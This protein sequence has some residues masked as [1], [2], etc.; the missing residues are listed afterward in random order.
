MQPEKRISEL[1]R[2]TVPESPRCVI[3]HKKTFFLPTFDA[4]GNF[5]RTAWPPMKTYGLFVIR[6]FRADGLKQLQTDGQ[7][8]DVVFNTVDSLS[9]GK[10]YIPNSSLISAFI[11]E[12]RWTQQE[13]QALEEEVRKLVIKELLGSLGDVVEFPGSCWIARENQCRSGKASTT[14]LQRSRFFYWKQSTP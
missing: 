9:D 10:T 14:H 6:N 12:E 5:Y 4:D 2:G 3:P 1:D 13:D 8:G 7:I 11:A